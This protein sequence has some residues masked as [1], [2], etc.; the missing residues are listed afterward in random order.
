MPP[1]GERD[2]IEPPRPARVAEAG[3]DGA[4]IDVDAG[5]VERLEQRHRDER[6]GDLVLAGEGERHRAVGPRRRVER[7]RQAPAGGAAHHALHAFRGVDERRPGRPGGGGDRV[8]RLVGEIAD[9]EGH[10]R[11]RDGRLLSRDRGARVAQP[12]LMI[13]IDRDDRGGHGITDVGGVE[14]AAE[15]D[16]DDR[17]VDPCPPQQLVG[18]GRHRLEERRL[19]GEAAVGE[20][21]GLDGEDVLDGPRRTRRRPPGRRRWRSALPAAPGAATCSVPSAARPPAGRARPS[22]RPIPCRWCRR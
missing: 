16:L 9:D 4:A 8:E 21:R 18:D 13:Q 20:A 6:V 11:S 7:D 14:T 2:A 22:P 1:V 17:D 5:V 12:R 10:A 15:A 3:L 19:I